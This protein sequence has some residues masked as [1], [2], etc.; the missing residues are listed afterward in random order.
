MFGSRRPIRFGREFEE[1]EFEF[2]EGIQERIRAVFAGI[3]VQR[4]MLTIEKQVG[5]ALNV[6]SSV[7]WDELHEKLEAW[8]KGVYEKRTGQLLGEAGEIAHDLDRN[9][10]LLKDALTDQS[11]LLKLLR[12]MTEGRVI[13]F[14]DKTK[15]PCAETR[16]PVELFQSHGRPPGRENQ[17]DRVDR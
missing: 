12:L 17:P 14:H 8:Q 5:E 15:R 11:A 2:K 13:T 7:S 6:E 3:A 10:T 9:Q 4:L 16:S 1:D